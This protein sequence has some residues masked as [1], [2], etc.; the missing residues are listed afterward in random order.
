MARRPRA[1]DASRCL[2]R[3]LGCHGTADHELSGARHAGGTHFDDGTSGQ[4][5]IN[6]RK[7][8]VAAFEVLDHHRYVE[9]ARIDDKH[10]QRLG[11]VAVEGRADVEDLVL[12]SRVDESDVLE[13]LSPRRAA[14]F[15][16]ASRSAPG[17]LE[18]DVEDEAIWL[19][20]RA[21]GHAHM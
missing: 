8:L 7:T 1:L 6:V 17:A 11:C 20:S 4:G 12:E 21:I 3:R 5:A 19:V 18:R 16:V 14:V 2:R 9:L 13:S 10:C 15:A